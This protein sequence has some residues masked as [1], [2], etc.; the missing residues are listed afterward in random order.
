[1]WGRRQIF[2]QLYSFLFNHLMV[3]FWFSAFGF[4]KVIILVI[5]IP[6]SKKVWIQ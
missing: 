3:I 5:Y 1:L 2:E 6:D 4:F